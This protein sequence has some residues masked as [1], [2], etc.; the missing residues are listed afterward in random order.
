MNFSYPTHT[1][2]RLGHL[3]YAY[4][5]PSYR[6]VRVIRTDGLFIKSFEYSELCHGKDYF[7]KWCDKNYFNIEGIEENHGTLTYWVS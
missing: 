4:N 7:S 5:I 1:V 6:E 3:T 2:Q